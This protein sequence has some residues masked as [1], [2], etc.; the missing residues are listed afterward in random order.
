MS[1]DVFESY[2]SLSVPSYY[3]LLCK[4]THFF[5]IERETSR[6][7]TLEQ[8]GQ[9]NGEGHGQGHRQGHEQKHRQR[10]GKGLKS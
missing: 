3:I 7:C 5:I 9:G 6:Q 2:R 1:F 4:F 8:T 10:Q